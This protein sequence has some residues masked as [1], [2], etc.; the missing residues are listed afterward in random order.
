MRATDPSNVVPLAAPV[1]RAAGRA[2]LLDE[3][4]AKQAL[5]R[6]G[7]PVPQGRVL[8]RTQALPFAAALGYPVVVKAVA[9]ALA[10]KTEAGAVRLNL[11]NEAEV[12]AALAAMAPLSD[13]FLVEQMVRGALAELLVGVQH[14]PQFGLTLT[15]GA[16][17][18]FVE[19]LRDSVTWLLPLSRAELLQALQ[20][21]AMWP[22]VTGYRGRAA[23]DV[24]AVLDAIEVIIAYATAH[25]DRLLELDVNP[26]LVLPQGQGVLAVDALISQIEED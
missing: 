16:G 4:S 5:A 22:M 17:G 11:M 12:E 18:V 20:S 7:L 6:F 3:A 10:H 21:L 15:L 8:D 2:R 23:G 1:P 19:L 13:Q 14:D 25:A 26:L 9:P 24:E